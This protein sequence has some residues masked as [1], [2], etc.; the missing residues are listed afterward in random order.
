MRR[1]R[2]ATMPAW[3]PRRASMS[4]V[5]PVTVRSPAYVAP[6]YVDLHHQ[7]GLTKGPLR[8]R[9]IPARCRVQIGR[10]RALLA[11]SWPAVA[12]LIWATSGN[13]GLPAPLMLSLQR[14]P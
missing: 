10:A 9:L 4:A 14:R 12:A 1:S 8:R 2:S 7:V 11:I 6:G 3:T 13:F 5:L